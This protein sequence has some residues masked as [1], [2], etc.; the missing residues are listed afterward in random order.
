PIIAL[1]AL[2]MPADAQQIKEAGF[3]GYITKPFRMRDLLRGIQDSI[4]QNSSDEST[5]QT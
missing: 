3:D 1:T 4:S 5:S 2:A